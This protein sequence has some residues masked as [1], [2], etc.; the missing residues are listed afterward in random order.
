LATQIQET[1]ISLRATLRTL[2][3]LKELKEEWGGSRSL[4]ITTCID[5][6]W[7]S[8]IGPKKEQNRN[9]FDKKD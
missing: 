7:Y 3:Q 5:R 9:V 1:I 4:I 8:E 6:A 2:K